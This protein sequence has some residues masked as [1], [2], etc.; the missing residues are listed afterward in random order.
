MDVQRLKHADFLIKSMLHV[1][2]KVYTCVQLGST[3]AV[4]YVHVV[5]SPVSLSGN[6]HKAVCAFQENTT[7][8]VFQD[9]CRILL[10]L[11]TDDDV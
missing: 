2:N 10:R 9:I 1:L 4:L 8:P 3:N 6:V 5:F 7:I 11:I